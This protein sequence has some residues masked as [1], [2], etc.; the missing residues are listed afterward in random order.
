MLTNIALCGVLICA[1]FAGALKAADN[2]YDMQIDEQVKLLADNNASVRSAAAESLGY[3]RAG[4][5]AD[6][7]E[8]A[9]KDP[10]SKVRRDA[11]LSLGWCG[12]RKQIDPL[13]N[14]LD[15]GNWTVRQGAWV[16][17]TN[18]TGMQWP[19][20]GLANKAKRQSQT[21]KWRSWWA[22]VKPGKI[23][24]EVMAL[25][26]ANA[27][28][29]ESSP[30]QWHV[31]RGLRAM[32][33]LG[34]DGA[35][36]QIIEILWSYKKQT[37]RTFSQKAMV[38]AGLRSLGRLGG[39]QAEEMLIEFLANPYWVRYAADALGDIGGRKAC[40]ALLKAY[41]DYARNIKGANPKLVPKDDRPG[42]DP[43]DRMYEVPYAIALALARMSDSF[44][45]ELLAQLTEL[46]PLL[47][48]NLPS[49]FDGIMIYELQSYQEIYAYLIELSGKRNAISEIAF[50]TLGVSNKRRLSKEEQSLLK[51]AK[52]SPGDVPNA[53]TWLPV[54]CRDKQYVP[55]LIKLLKHQNGWVRINAAKTLMF[56][57][58]Q[59]A[60]AA[61]TEILT[62]SKP[63]AEYGYNGKFFFMKPKFGYA[64]Y[65]DVPPRWRQAFVQALGVLK[66]KQ[67]VPKLVELLND[68]RNVLEVRYAAAESLDRISTPPAIEALK[69][70][71]ANHPFHSI[72][73][74][75]REALWRRGIR[76]S[77]T[78]AGSVK[79]LPKTAPDTKS[80][81][82]FPPA[83]VFIKGDNVMPNNFQIDIWRMTYSTTDSGPTY[84]LGNN[85]YVL[86]PAN[87]RGKVTQLTHF[88]D[89]YVADCEVSWDGSKIIFAH[90]GGD[91]DPWW[92]IYEIGADGSGMRQLTYGPYHDVQPAYMGDGRVIFS[93]SRI[94][95]RDEY[96][97]YPATGL[98][99][100]N[101]DG[102]DIHCIGFNFGRDNEPAVM[103][104]GRIVFSRLEL[105][106]SRMK[107][108]LTLHSVFPD[109]TKDITL[110]GPERRDFW[111]Q[112][113]K[114]SG[115]KWWGEVAPRHRVLRLTQ[116]QY[117]DSQRLICMTTA[118]ATL[119]GPGRLKERIIRA[120][121]TR[122]VTS[123]F[124]LSDGRILCA[125][126]RRT[127]NLKDI[128]LGLYVMDSDT[129][130]LTLLYNDPDTAEF[131]PR[132]LM[133]RRRPRSLATGPSERSGAYTGK[134]FCRSVFDSQESRVGLRGKLVRVVEGQPVV[135]RHHT[136]L[137]KAGPAWKNHTGTHARVLGTVPLAADGSFFVNIP[138][139]RL[140]HFQVLD[141][142]RRVVGN[143]QVWMYARPEETRGCV[144]CHEKPD[145]TAY[146]KNGLFPQAAKTAPIDCLP[147]GGEFSYR[148]K[149]WNKGTLTDEG[150]ERT[151]TVRAV[152][153]ISR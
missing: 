147:T 134:F 103:P 145:A 149:F 128:D 42:L 62:A 61:I 23:P 144:G 9:L 130:K 14:A 57:N 116:P 15:D 118:G 132:P 151:R 59:S 122:S 100:M 51:L 150:E 139:D 22:S 143:Q 126:S 104:D 34:G 50:Q 66:A 54:I 70:A 96:H 101:S 19:F 6:A 98:T 77:T 95:V 10:S 105:F 55:K 120:D 11:A 43:S 72:K 44:D 108:E 60:L 121:Q 83:V 32:G 88:K 24:D 47:T 25:L 3:L 20:D 49:D 92:H 48:A 117:F 87:S 31:E 107:T 91:T 129:G 80:Y 2:P 74:F 110:Y 26:R 21:K 127:F 40:R 45:E 85:L 123:P 90:R 86:R 63:E 94:G 148:A 33:A 35:A 30:R 64:E 115:E 68:D 131:E 29:Y 65:N 37:G 97:G 67:C 99:V 152:N 138:A 41:P 133:P 109:G 8:R 106:Y 93:S 7:L 124:P 84:R 114:D 13:L 75:A 76:Q 111:R 113:T 141:S 1:A 135:A 146:M 52:T 36:Q 119:I 27:D 89:G 82:V 38:Q 53:A 71:Q 112:V 78:T 142:D 16:A 69:A 17:L 125:S 137:N 81:P 153:L 4:K 28:K 73:M 136:H 46:A 58:E 18:L 79:P 140:I 39:Q 12:G 102:T 56:M 5:A